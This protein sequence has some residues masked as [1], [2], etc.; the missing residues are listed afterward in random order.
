M[1]TI[2]IIRT[3]YNNQLTI[4]SSFGNISTKHKINN[5]STGYVPRLV[6]LLIQT[7]STQ[8]LVEE[9]VSIYIFTTVYCLIRND[10]AN[11]I[12]SCKLSTISVCTNCLNMVENQTFLMVFL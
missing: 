12:S 7:D 9:S 10:G 8:V 6:S 11:Q 1:I 4:Q 5:L 2:R 3:T